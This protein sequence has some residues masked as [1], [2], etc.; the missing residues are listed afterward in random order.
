[1]Y[2][3]IDIG[4]TDIKYALMDAKASIVK[5]SKTETPMAKGST[6]EDLL[7]VIEKMIQE[8][9]A[10]LQGIAISMPGIIDSGKGYAYTGGSV[11]YLAKQHLADLIQDRFEIPATIENDGKCSALA[12]LWQGSLKDCRNGAV[13]LLGTGVGGGL[14]IDGKLYK[15]S[16]FAAGELSYML[17]DHHQEFSFFGEDGSSRG[18][19]NQAREK[20]S[21]TSEGFNGIEFFELVKQGDVVA[22]EVL[23]AYTQTLAKQLYNLQA[24]L[25]L[26]IFAIGG[27]ISQQPLLIQSLEAQIK[28]YCENHPLKSMLPFIPQPKITACSFY[29]DSNLIGALYAHLSS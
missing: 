10:E 22:K 18:L 9:A 3:V 15:G 8:F 21:I 26:D 7:V 14:I 20:L 27:G 29:N 28:D 23:E 12:E 6:V 24:V 16:S 19:I 13:V 1:M 2:L 4:G 5:K 17:L 25:D 11:T